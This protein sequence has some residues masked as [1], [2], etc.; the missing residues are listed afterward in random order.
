M[1]TVVGRSLLVA[2]LVA[3]TACSNG[4]PF[5]GDD[6]GAE[7]GGHAG[8][9]GASG[10]HG[11][12]GG[13]AGRGGSGGGSGSIGTGGA[14]SGGKGGTGGA[15]SGGAGGT[16]PQGGSAGTGTGGS[17]TGGSATGGSGS[18]G[19]GSGGMG[20][21]GT[22]SGGSGTGGAPMCETGKTHLCAGACVS[23][24]STSSCGTSSCQAC[25][26]PAG[27][28]ATCDGSACGFTC[29]GSTP[30]QCAAAGI[31]IAAGGCCTNTDC[32]T[33]AGGQTGTCDT[34]MHSCNYSCTGSTNSC[35]VGSTTTCIPST[36]CCTNSDCKTAC[37]SCD[38]TS[39]TCV[40][41]KNGNDP[42]GRCAGTCDSAGTCKSKQGQTCTTVAAGCISGTSC[43]DGYCC[44]NS[45]TGGCMACDVVGKEGTCSPISAHEAPHG[46]RSGCASDGS[47]CGGYCDGAGSCAFP[48]GSCGGSMCTGTGTYTPAPAC[49][50]AGKCV[51]ASSQ[52]CGNFS[53]NGAT[54]CNTTCSSPAQCVANAVCAGSICTKCPSGQ[55]VCGNACYTTSSDP[56]H[57]G[58]ACNACS[59][60]TP[61][62]VN[63]SCTCRQSSPG[64][65]VKNAGIG[66]SLS[67]WNP[68]GGAAYS[69]ADVESCSGSGSISLSNLG[70][71]VHQCVTGGIN[72]GFPYVFGFVYQDPQG[73]QG[74]CDL[75]TFSDTAC[76]TSDGA[77]S[78]AT[79]LVQGNGDS[80]VPGSFAFSTGGNTHSIQ[81]HCSAAA[82]G[83]VYDDFYISPASNPSY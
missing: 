15:A 76:A 49:N 72:T 18:G 2:F 77:V 57:C 14:A 73:G 11:G 58:A 51:T 43:V 45:C 3:A 74:F 39:H 46:S 4:R 22:G 83:G 13:T 27:G 40:A 36:G 60:S 28:T 44:N 34:A 37:T 75:S 70:A 5:T 69:T 7:G 17:G 71:N 8:A 66:G 63:G 30:K 21:G 23:N 16:A 33:N 56:N 55:T 6:G 47:S 24:T 19:S 64:N 50:G 62:C 26:P 78:G 48:T 80:W 32:P 20:T 65:L 53:C 12:S 79:V 31:C 25:T 38:T 68:D 52:S 59:G 9:S 10:G 82:G 35:T 29:G 67:Q 54:S 61:S 1:K 81:I 41:V 42:N